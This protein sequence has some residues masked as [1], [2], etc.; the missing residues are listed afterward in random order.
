MDV[1]SAWPLPDGADLRDRLL[2]AYADEARGYHDT[3]HLAEVLGRLDELARHGATYD[4]VPVLLAAWFHDAVYD[5]ERDAEERSAAW[6]EA[7]LPELVDESLV[8]EVARLVRLTE[9]HRPEADDPSGCA[10]SDADLGI[11]ATEPA[12]YATYV[13]AVRVDYAHVPDDVFVEGRAAVL[14]DLLSKPHLFHTDYAREAWEAPARANVEAEL[15][16]LAAP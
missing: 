8:R 13:A 16:R 7:E 14:R 6:A 3:T 11:L 9:T 4:R 15:A 5:G 12:R 10:L 1:L 2:A